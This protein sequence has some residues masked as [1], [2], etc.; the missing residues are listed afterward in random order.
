ME[1]A[2]SAINEPELSQGLGRPA[3]VGVMS[4]DAVEAAPNV[5]KVLFENDRV[6][7]LEAR[8]RPGDSSVTHSH[9]N[10]LAYPIG[11][12]KVTFT[13]GSRSFDVEMKAGQAMWREASEHSAQ[14][15]GTGDAVVLI[16][17]VK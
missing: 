15:S 14:N 7:L 12:C 17:E 1:R 11:D 9:P 10:Y 13:S 8:I 2:R 4:R 6:R 3:R 16:F 5:Y